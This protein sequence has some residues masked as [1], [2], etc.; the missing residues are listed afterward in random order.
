MPIVHSSR[1]FLS[2]IAPKI[3]EVVEDLAEVAYGLRMQSAETFEQLHRQ[4]NRVDRMVTGALD[5]VD[6]T[7][8]YVV[9]AVIRPMRQVAGVLAAIKATVESLRS[10]QKQSR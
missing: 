3:E 6:R 7:G 5:A 10:H 9:G 8:N 4:S 2:H 1:E